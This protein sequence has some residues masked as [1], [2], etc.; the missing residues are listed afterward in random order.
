[1][2]AQ[3]VGC[4]HV[5]V[6]VPVFNSAGSLHE[7]VRR[8]RE[9]LDRQAIGYEIILVDDSSTDGSWS[10]IESVADTNPEVVGVALSRN[11]GQHNALLAGIRVA[12][13][14][15]T[16]TIDDDLQNPPEEIGKLLERLD[17]GFDVV[18]GTPEQPE[19]GRMRVFGSRF[20]K[21][22]LRQ[23]MSAETAEHVSPFRAFRTQLRDAF[24]EQTGPDVFI[25]VMLAWGSDRFSHVTVAH[26]PR[27]TGTSNYTNRRLVRQAVNMVTGFSATPLRLASWLGFAST[28]FG[29]AILVYVLVNYLVNGGKVPGFTF[30]AATVAL[31]A[32]IQLFALGIIGE[33][34]ARV[35]VRA[36]NEPAYV[37]RAS[38]A[39]A[40]EH[41]SRQ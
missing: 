30:I 7:L 15:V 35:H 34:L 33:Y 19:H 12:Q 11:V 17:Q 9:A 13:G 21:L 27:Q 36:M 22:A 3:G 8:T 25:D 31:F 2:P 38:T 41:H 16:V 14:A 24:A 1:M 39:H 20:T 29:G 40:V 37:I 28:L 26:A 6:V 10:V 5:T 32:G 18:Y 4:P 23:F